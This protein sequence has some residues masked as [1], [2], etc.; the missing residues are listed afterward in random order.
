MKIFSYPYP[1]NLYT[2]RLNRVDHWLAMRINSK[3]FG[4]TVPSC[5]C[6]L[7]LVLGHL[8]DAIFGVV[9]QTLRFSIAIIF[10]IG[11]KTVVIYSLAQI[12]RLLLPFIKGIV[13]IKANLNVFLPT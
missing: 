2:R 3:Q 12:S 10:R 8:S 4:L 9:Q 11:I 5:D 1:V 7:S 13:T 6:S